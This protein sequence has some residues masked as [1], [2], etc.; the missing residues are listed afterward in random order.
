LFPDD[1]VRLQIQR[2]IKTLSSTPF[3]KREFN[4]EAFDQ[5]LT[6]LN[7]DRERSGKKY[8]EI[9]KRLITIF[10]CRGCLIPKELS[11]ETIDRV[12]TKNLR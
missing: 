5:L 3:K 12:V 6:W 9:R 1:W 4:Q 10:T 11:D 2:G 8:E 7:P